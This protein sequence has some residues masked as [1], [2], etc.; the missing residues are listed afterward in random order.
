[1]LGETDSSVYATSMTLRYVRA[2]PLAF[3]PLRVSERAA[4]LDLKSAYDY[5]IP[6]WGKVLVKT[7][8]KV[9]IPAGY[10]GRI[11]P[12]S[13]LALHHSIAVGAGVIDEDYTGII[14]ILLFNH[15][16]EAFKIHCGD[17]VAQL[18]CEKIC[19]PDLEE[20]SSLEKTDRGEG[21]FGSTGIGEYTFLSRFIAIFQVYNTKILF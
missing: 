4:G 21:G 6:P 9:Q 8:L 14:G 12:R 17:R 11:A 7:D 15:S 18:I 1:M 16:P 2:S 5:E 13:G 20:V 10:Y 19:L 3:A